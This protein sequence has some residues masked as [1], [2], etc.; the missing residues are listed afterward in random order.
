MKLSYGGGTLPITRHHMLPIKI[1]VPKMGYIF[2][3]FT[4]GV[5]ADVL[6]TLHTAAKTAGYTTQPDSN[7]LLLKI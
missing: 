7:T 2:F 3:K 4:K 6:Q 5:T 1:P